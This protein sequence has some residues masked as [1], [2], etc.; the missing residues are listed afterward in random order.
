LLA[1]RS[2]LLLALSIK[3]LHGCSHVTTA[4]WKH[5]P[6]TGSTLTSLAATAAAAAAAAALLLTW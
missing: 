1:E 5:Q 2:L 3:L 4:A 6:D